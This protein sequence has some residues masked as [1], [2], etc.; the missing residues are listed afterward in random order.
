M[1]GSLP[2]TKPPLK[3]FLK[4]LPHHPSTSTTLNV[5]LATATE[6]RTARRRNVCEQNNT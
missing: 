2:S 5:G 4:I 1:V 3:G 6:A